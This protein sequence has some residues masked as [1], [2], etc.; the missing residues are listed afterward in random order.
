ML[1]VGCLDRGP[2][3]HH[4]G[5]LD[6]PAA[7][8]HVQGHVVRPAHLPTGFRPQG[9]RTRTTTNKHSTQVTGR[10][11]PGYSRSGDYA[12]A[13]QVPNLTLRTSQ[14]TSGTR[15]VILVQVQPPVL[16]VLHPEHSG[17]WTWGLATPW[18]WQLLPFLSLL[19]WPGQGLN[20]QPRGLRTDASSGDHREHFD[21]D[22]DEDQPLNPGSLFMFC[23]IFERGFC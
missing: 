23:S 13:L 18:T 4:A 3:P 20:P 9:R 14:A 1:F 16:R 5:L 17:S 15:R 22:L 6:R 8:A 2:G 10:A 7:P 11:W 21:C 19:G 12:R